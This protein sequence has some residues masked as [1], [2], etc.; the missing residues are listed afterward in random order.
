M[1]P[2]IFKVRRGARE[3]FVKAAG[4]GNELPK[5]PA[6]NLILLE[7]PLGMPLHAQNPVSRGRALD[8]FD[9][10]VLR[11]AG[12]HAQRIAWR[13]D[14]LVMTGVDGNRPGAGEF[15]KLGVRLDLGGVLD[16][17]AP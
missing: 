4:L 10:I 8:R 16:Y 14:R 6:R 9:D 17:R 5:D 15:G 13:S 11:R 1:L 2:Y 3:T 12:H 7:C